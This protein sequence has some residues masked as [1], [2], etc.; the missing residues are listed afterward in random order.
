MR[1]VIAISAVATLLTACSFF[2]A[3]GPVRT[4]RAPTQIEQATPATEDTSPS[5]TPRLDPDSQPGQPPLNSTPK[6][7]P[8]LT[9]ADQTLTEK[10]RWCK[11][12]ALDNL[13][14]IVY[15][16]F[17]QLDPLNMDDIDRTIWRDRLRGGS[18]CYRLYGSEPLNA[19]N[20]DRRNEQ[21]KE[22]CLHKLIPLV[23]S[24]WDTIAEAAYE[25]DNPVA[26]EIPNQ[27]VRIMRWMHL[28]GEELLAMDEPPYELLKRPP[29][30]GLRLR[31]HRPLRSP[32]RRPTSRVRRRI[33]D[34]VVGPSHG[35][36]RQPLP[37][38]NGL[39][40]ILPPAFHRVLDPLRPASANL[41]PANVHALP[42]EPNCPRGTQLQDPKHP[43]ELPLPPP[44]LSPPAGS[45]PTLP[46]PNGACHKPRHSIPTA[47]P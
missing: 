3:E 12:W 5:P 4:T 35:R 21:Y 25:R 39:P 46:T 7:P 6:G 2:D 10:R 24:K 11:A 18:S 15:A 23:D 34:R 41:D 38:R 30:P 32:T 13:E 45:P 27:H 20:A 37:P 9:K 31:K 47:K 33:H 28:T 19:G 17:L 29:W 42:W 36:L 22:S 1:L 14:P 8:Q 40:Q 43:P 44:A 16:E 26:Y